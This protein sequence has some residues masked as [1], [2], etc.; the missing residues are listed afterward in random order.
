M[1]SP[2]SLNS[3]SEEFYQYLEETS[4]K[5]SNTPPSYVQAIHILNTVF[6]ATRPELLAPT[7]NLWLITSSEQL[8]AIRKVILD[9]VKKPGCGIFQ[10][11]DQRQ[12]SYWKN[13]FCSAAVRAFA[14]FQALQFRKRDML[15]ICEQSSNPVKLAKELE[16]FKLSV[17]PNVKDELGLSL[18][19]LE[20]KDR[21]V[22]RKA[23][24]NQQK[25]R[26]LV[27]WNYQNQC[28]ISGLPIVHSLQ[29]SH[30]KDW[31][32]AP[33]LRLNAT[34]G[35]CLAAQY[36]LAFDN[37]LI[38]LDE[39]YRLVIS[40]TLHEYVTN[41]AYREQFLKYEG[42]KIQMPLKYAPSLELLA[43]HRELLAV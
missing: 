26:T 17:E 6:K 37:H 10:V 4:S 29:A 23:R 11:A 42:R 16:K 15:Y 5:G 13:N 40:T 38:T 1:S 8:A 2:P 21:L 14:Q 43:Q 28:C 24:E 35:L 34:N 31:S 9:E 20:G 27:L 22:L 3:I 12:K 19:A 32:E 33:D 7:G 18:D 36:H 41:E 39:K 25:F 30:I